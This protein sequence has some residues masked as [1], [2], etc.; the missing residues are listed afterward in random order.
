MLELYFRKGNQLTVSAWEIMKK[1]SKGNLSGVRKK[2][3]DS[4]MGNV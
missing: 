2:N 4:A 3:Y 1:E